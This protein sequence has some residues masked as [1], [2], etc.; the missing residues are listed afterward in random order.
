MKGCVMPDQDRNLLEAM[1]EQLIQMAGKHHP[2]RPAFS[3]LWHAH[4]VV[5]EAAKEVDKP[6]HHHFG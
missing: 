1:A 6:G 3:A 5:R 4:R 2:G